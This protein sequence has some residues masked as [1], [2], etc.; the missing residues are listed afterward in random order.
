M[1][2]TGILILLLILLAIPV[3]A[4]ELTAPTVPS[5]AEDFMV[6]EPENLMDGIRQILREAV[7][8]IRP[9]I[10]EASRVCL[11]IIGVAMLVS[12]L[13]IFPAGVEKS[14][15]LAEVVAVSVMFL[16]TAGALIDLGAE[17]VMQVSEYG[18]LLL[19]VMAAAL[20]SQGGITVSTALYTVTAAF[21]AVLS[22]LISK[23]LLPLL[24]LFV[25]IAV[26]HR[27]TGE[28]LLKS[29]L[30]GIK[31]LMTW[32]LKT[33]LYVFTGFIS[34]TGVI[35][36]PTDAA[37]LKAAK[38]TISG[39]VP[40]VGGILSDASEAV[41]VSAGVVKNAMGMY[42][43]FAVLAIWMDPFLRIGTHYLMLRFT[44][45]ICSIF[46]SKGVSNLIQDF[47]AVMGFLLAMTGSV[48]LMI[49]ISTVCFMRGVM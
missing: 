43:L 48:C 9:D 33:I 32:L 14:T 25:A 24:Y 40:V 2:R 28:G 30:D 39:L 12:L 38:L 17:T 4:Q 21:D 5:V 11:G 47:A 6:S 3:D 1:R 19:P 36:G 29:M 49:L 34:I 10:K 46:G 26:A 22:S 16:S 37:A 7:G 15:D 42:G 13:R 41:L 23:L 45:A 18:K 35:S 20:A 8:H 31:W 44:G 27:A